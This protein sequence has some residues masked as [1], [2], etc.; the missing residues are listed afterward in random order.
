MTK[1]TITRNFS[2]PN[3]TDQ[4]LI[5]TNIADHLR[6]V[7]NDLAD[8]LDGGT[9]FDNLNATVKDFDVV[10]GIPFNVGGTRRSKNVLGMQILLTYGATITSVSSSINSQNEGVMTVVCTPERAKIKVAVYGI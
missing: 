10:S 2:I 8:M 9:S 7:T 3:T 6:E 1:R 4:T 5:N